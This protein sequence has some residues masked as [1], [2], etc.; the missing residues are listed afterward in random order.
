MK[1]KNTQNNQKTLRSK[2][3]L[4]LLLVLGW[5]TYV[6]GQTRNNP[7]TPG[8]LFKNETIGTPATSAL[9]QNIVYPIDYSTG[10]PEIKIPLYE[11]KNGDITLPIYLTYHASGVK[12]SDAA[13]WTG[14]GWSLVAE[15]MI[16]RTVQGHAD[17]SKTRT[18]YFKKDAYFN[19]AYVSTMA[20][21]Y[22]CE[23]PDEYCYRLLSK[24]GM[25]MYSM[26]PKDPTKQFLPLPYEDI[27]IDWKGSYFQ[28]VD[29][30]GT[31]YKFAGGLESGGKNLQTVGW[32]A[33]SIVAP[34][35]K[36]S[37]T[38]TY[39]SQEVR[40]SVKVHNDYMTILDNFS[41]KQALH[42]KRD[43]ATNISP[44]LPDEWM[45]D[46][47]IYSTINNQTQSYQRNEEG[48]VVS[49]WSGSFPAVSIH[50]IDTSSQPLR[51]I[52]FSQGKVVFTQE[53]DQPRLQKITIYDLKGNII[54]EIQF[55]YMTNNNRLRHRYYLKTLVTVDNKGIAQETYS[56]DYY[57][58]QYLPDPGDRSI[59]FW[60]YFNGVRRSEK[61]TL[62]PQQ[63]IQT[64]QGQ[65]S[66]YEV[67]SKI[68][69]VNLTFG[70]ALS[71]EANEE[72]MAYGTLSSITYPT[73]S[74]DEFTYEGH[75]YKTKN[76]TTRIVGGL[77]IKQIKTKHKYRDLK[78][79]TFKYGSN[80]NGNGVSATSD[81]FNYFMLDQKIYIGDP[82]IIISSG[83]SWTYEPYYG[84]YITA[85]QRTFFTNSLRPLTFDGGS[86]VMY[87]T[88]TEYN[89]TPQ[90]NSGKTVYNY[91]IQPSSSVPTERNT[92]QNNQH[93]SWTHGHLTGKTVY[94]NNNGQY[95]PIE[96]TENFYSN[97]E[98]NFGKILV[99]EAG[100][101]VIIRP[102]SDG[103]IPYEAEYDND[104][105]RTEINIGAK[106]LKET[107]HSVYCGKDTI[108]SSTR[109]EYSD[110]SS[111]Y[112][113]RIIESESK[114]KRVKQTT[115]LTYPKDYKNIYPYTDMV[116]RNILSQAVKKE[117]VRNN[118][119]IGIETPFIKSSDDIYR[120]GK[121]I[122]RRTPTGEGDT[123]ATYLYDTH[124]K[125]RQET[126]DDKENIVYLY[127]YQ[128]HYIIAKIENATFAEV[129]AKLGYET[130]EKI[131]SNRIF[132]SSDLKQ[133]NDL[134]Y[135]LP[136]SRLTTYTYQPLVGITS[137]TDPLGLTTFYNYDS[138]GRLVKSYVINNNQTELITSQDYHY[139]EE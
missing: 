53:P 113:T 77:R 122:V 131:A 9:I 38:F 89:G 52:H 126:R 127:G 125:I 104:Y 5:Q 120:P 91:N 49:D 82:L 45:Q 55:N 119:Y 100:A 4:S 93:T 6:G 42:T 88:V 57:K 2:L 79:R 61:E 48:G 68:Y 17:D 95:K 121:L 115:T 124:G 18:C 96:R 94:S 114:N 40:Y 135:S 105:V 132:N 134:R 85:R 74:T 70:S 138:L 136:A 71:R 22:A 108:Y 59:D 90:S 72:Y 116:A 130:I 117:Y 58:Y 97:N 84:E 13:G 34:N 112:P 81:D 111:I 128:N 16:T 25:F 80:E 29:D 26:E 64:T 50:N 63:T 60:G 62:I 24:Q 109:Y 15:P 101:N 19:N 8:S 41:W 54:K 56:F 98:K 107:A 75:R 137:I 21:G 133:I 102:A 67:Y 106:L 118:S 30:D 39:A 110:P 35:C 28:I 66:K 87:E 32:K 23:Q 14:L 27:R 47:I 76:G 12:L 103:S 20:K 11:V 73:G 44:Y 31:L 78:I 83:G 139:T 43:V 1:Q 36:D 86:T 69:D 3:L 92:I 129:A 123:R 7:L 65:I 37:I 33:S 51:E 46:P 99:G 10:L